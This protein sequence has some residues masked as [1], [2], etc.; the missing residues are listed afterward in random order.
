MKYPRLQFRGETGAEDTNVKV[1]EAGDHQQ[2]NIDWK[3]NSG[4]PRYT[5]S[6]Q[7]IFVSL[8]HVMV[9]GTQQAINEYLNTLNT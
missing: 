7:S 2:I 4:V 6:I 5:T 3:E 8:I 1:Y 9:H